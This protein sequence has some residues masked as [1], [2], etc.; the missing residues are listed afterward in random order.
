MS[1][2]GG[3]IK[4]YYRTKPGFWRKS[5]AHF[6]P[7]LHNKCVHSSSG[8]PI[9]LKFHK[10]LPTSSWNICAWS[11]MCSLSTKALKRHRSNIKN[12]LK[13][14]TQPDKRPINLRSEC[15]CILIR[16]FLHRVLQFCLPNIRYV[17]VFHAHNCNKSSYCKWYR[18]EQ[19]RD[20]R[21]RS[22]MKEA[23]LKVAGKT[24]HWFSSSNPGFEA[25]QVSLAFSLFF[26]Q[27]AL[28]S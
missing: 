19:R 18:H 3:N 21:L 17:S 8:H 25:G 2:R 27:I 14:L 7:L 15:V 5:L 13:N 6:I 26:S 24:Y 1:W 28:V 16:E 11:R 20:F 9:S 10:M 4:I 23:D 12:Q 22:Y